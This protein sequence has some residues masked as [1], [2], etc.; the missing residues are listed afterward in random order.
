M[1]NEQ[2]GTLETK[3]RELGSGTRPIKPD[4][5]NGTGGAILI[6]PRLS[7]DELL[8]AR[9]HPNLRSPPCLPLRRVVHPSFEI[10]PD[11]KL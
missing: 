6:D 7:N 5:I 4:R 3:I 2:H 8:P 10:S 11:T 1:S 9:A